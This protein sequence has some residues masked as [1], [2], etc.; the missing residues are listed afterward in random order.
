[1]YEFIE[2]Q[3]KNKTLIRVIIAIIAVPFVFFGVESYVGRSG[4]GGRAV[5]RVGSY[6]ISQEEFSQALRERQ[7]AIHRAMPGRVDPEMLDNPQLRQAILEGLIQRRVL[8]QHAQSAGVT[9]T[10][11]QLKAAIDGHEFFRDE[12]GRFSYD[13]YVEFLRSESMTPAVF[14]ARMRQDLMIRHLANGV[15]ES[16]FLSRTGTDQLLRVASQ[17]REVSHATISP[18]RYLPNVKIEAEAVKQYYDANPGEFRVPEQVRVEYVTLSIETLMQGVEISPD[19]TRKYYDSNRRQFGVEES[20]QAA[21]ILI[22]PDVGEGAE[23]KPKARARAEEIHRELLKNPKRFAE[24]AKK[25]SQDP[26]SAAAGGDLGGRI[27][28]GSMKDTPDLERAIFELKPGEISA[29][30]ET[31]HGFHIIRVTSVE[32]ATIRPFEEVRGQIEQELRKQ[33]AARRFAEMAE[34]FNNTVYEQSESLMPAA[35]LAQSKP[36]QSGWIMRDSAEPPLNHPRLLAAVFSQETLKERRNTE[37]IE[38][39]P[40]TLVAARVLE[41]KPASTQPFD[42]ARAELEKRLTL[43][44]AARLASEEGRR[45]LEELGQ[46]KPVKVDWSEPVLVSRD[47]T[48]DLPEPVLR[49]TFRMDVSS[50]PAYSAIDSPSGAYVL[51]RVTRAQAPDNLPPEKATQLTDQLRDVVAQETFSAYIASL[52]EKAGVKVFREQL[53]KSQ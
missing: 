26:G 47:E 34:R 4:D 35:E 42:E 50:L 52:R 25:Y 24:A 8:I 33:Q 31:Q 15:A 28:P 13:R 40:G 10:D 1:M 41:H 7:N 12:N 44:E 22:A 16:G 6:S 17:Q 39:A 19:E 18:E 9:V 30:V 48:K 38:I 51:L 53:E 3:K 2:R 23:A 49:Q 36:Q 20:R 29:P 32:P 21:H 37:A 27:S 46:G 43:R 45:M 14:E 11:S 5:A